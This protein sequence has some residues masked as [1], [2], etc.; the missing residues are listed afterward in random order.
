MTAAAQLN[1]RF[2][3]PGLRFRDDP[4]GLVFAESDSP[5]ATA[6][7]CLQGAHLVT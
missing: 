4:S 7:I 1:A 5:Q 3:Q 2:A 6:S